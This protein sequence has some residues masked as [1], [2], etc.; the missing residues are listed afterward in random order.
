MLAIKVIIE[1]LLLGSF[2]Y[3][4]CAFGIRNGAIGMVHLYSEEVQKRVVELGL[5]TEE[6]IRNRNI[7]FKITCL[8]GYIAYVLICVYFINKAR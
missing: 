3:L 6:N 7:Y 4:I 2:L 1:G 5:T 8:I